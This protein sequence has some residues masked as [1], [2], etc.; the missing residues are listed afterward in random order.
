MIDQ[1]SFKFGSS[2]DGKPLDIAPGAMTVLVGPNNSGKSLTLRELHTYIHKYG[3]REE[4]ANIRDAFKVI[5]AIR[6]RLP[7]QGSIRDAILSEV[8]GDIRPFLGA[9]AATKISPKELFENFDLS[10]LGHILTQLNQFGHLLLLAQTEKIDPSLL[11]VVNG[12]AL[13]KEPT[14]VSA[15]IAFLRQLI[16]YIHRNEDILSAISSKATSTESF[17]LLGTGALQMNGYLHHFADHTVLLDGKHRLALVDPSETHSLHEQPRTTMMRL[18]HSGQDLDALRKY[19]FQAFQRHLAIDATALIRSRFVLAAEHPGS[20]ERNLAAAEALKYFREA[21]DLSELSDGVKSYVGLHA[22]LL[23]RDYKVI[24]IDEPEAFLHPPLA[25]LL[26][27]N[28]TN[29]ATERNATIVAATHSPFFLMG[30]LEAQRST[31]VVRLGYRNGI[32]TARSLPAKELQ[33]IMNDPLLRSTRVLSALFHQCAVVCE[34]ASDQAFYD[35][36]NERLRIASGNQVNESSGTYA[37]DCLFINSQGKHTVSRLMG[38]LR[39]MGIPSAGIVDLDILKDN[40]VA[41]DLLRDAG[42]GDGTCHAIGQLRGDVFAAF[43]EEAKNRSLA[44]DVEQ[45]PDEKRVNALAGKLIQNGGVDNLSDERSQRDFAH[46]VR[47]LA[48]YGIFA[49][50]RGELEGWLPQLGQAKTEKK[51]W[52]AAIFKEMGSSDDPETYLRPSAGDVWDFMRGIANWI[53]AQQKVS[54]APREKRTQA[55]LLKSAAS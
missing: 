31:T 33:K 45:Q 28:L 2:P 29:L 39:R 6:P 50:E 8:E 17:E 27:Y 47:T 37:R 18:L 20:R 46:F 16:D 22:T 7:E 43:R 9:L 40:A 51:H 34:G 38:T 14:L 53:E 35:E 54:S 30:C 55:I 11:K 4:F 15:A 24:L 26:G 52:L 36:I 5:A 13:A 12:D 42:A 1:I 44:E 19:V 23:S 32:A 49:L 10:Y 41:V 48:D 3:D 25:R 21:E